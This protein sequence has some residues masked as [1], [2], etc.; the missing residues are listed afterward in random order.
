[1]TNVQST[2]DARFQ[3]TRESVKTADGQAL[4]VET[5]VAAIKHATRKGEKYFRIHDSGDFFS[6]A[7]VRMWAEVC[8][9]LPEV[10]F[11][12]PTRVWQMPA[13]NAS[14]NG[15]KPFRVMTAIDLMFAELLKLAALPNVTIR[16][17]ALNFGDAA[18]VVPGLHAGSAASD[19]C[20]VHDGLLCPAP[21]QGNNCGDCRVC[22]D[23]NAVPVTYHKH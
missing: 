12:A 2:Q 4:W 15:L 16:P 10:K 8:K 23:L 20:N 21:T 11:W 3:W 14:V 7:Y 19:V 22:W 13:S 18:P 9:A 5:M 17:S 1:M 6:P